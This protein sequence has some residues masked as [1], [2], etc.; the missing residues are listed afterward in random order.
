PATLPPRTARRGR[1]RVWRAAPVARRRGGALLRRGRSGARGRG[2]ARS[3]AGGGLGGPPRRP[4][5]VARTGPGGAPEPGAPAS[6]RGPAAGRL[7]E[8]G[9]VGLAREERLTRG[10]GIVVAQHLARVLVDS[11]RVAV[12]RLAERHAQAVCG[13]DQAGVLAHVLLRR[14]FPVRRAVAAC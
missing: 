3:T 7:R 6:R 11:L 9:L 14:G 13:A 10:P 1:E 8:I 4:P 5:S 12:V 2:V